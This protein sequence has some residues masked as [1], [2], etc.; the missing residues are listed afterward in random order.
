MGVNKRLMVYNEEGVRGRGKEVVLCNPVVVE[1][2]AEEDYFEEGCLSFPGIYADV[3]VRWPRL[4]CP[5]CFGRPRTVR[6]K[7][8]LIRGRLTPHL[9]RMHTH[10]AEG[11]PAVWLRCLC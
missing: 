10:L 6:H 1:T 2:S 5:A 4:A 9:R 8:T 7:Y 3:K 11:L